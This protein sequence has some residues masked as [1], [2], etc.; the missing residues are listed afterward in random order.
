MKAAVLHGRNDI[1][2]EQIPRPEPG[3]GEV[4]V[5]VRAAGICGSDIPRVLGDGAHF[6]P[7]VLGH[8]FSGTVAA[9]GEGVSGLSVGDT[10]SGAPLKPCMKCPDCARGNYS[11]CKHYSF[12]GSREQGSFAEYVVLPAANAVRYSPSVPFEQAAMFEPATVSLH[13]V[14]L[15][16]AEPGEFTA[17]CGGGTIGMFAAQ[18][19]RIFGARRV[20]VFDIVE[21]RLDLARRLG[22][23]AVFNTGREGW[24]EEALAYT[25]GAGYGCVYETAGSPVTMR[26]AFE[27]AANRSSVC[28]IGTPH[29]DVVFTPRMWENMNRKEFRLTGSWMS[30]SAPFPGKEW[31][32]TSDCFSDGRL[33]FDE[34][35]IFR[36]FPLEECREAF[37]LFRVPGQVRGKVMF[38]I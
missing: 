11:L 37:D 29:E 1:R 15:N 31:T 4:L 38:V 26:M 2:C 34:S 28:F 6:F 9:L 30:Y 17:I 23:D 21:E 27:L 24:K 13:G 3:P 22:A 8:E 14:L 10:V 19:S 5:R 18:W 20:A 33:K 16:R 25:G 35:F 32:L 36:R 7:I 12:I